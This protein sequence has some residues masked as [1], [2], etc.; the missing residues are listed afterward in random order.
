MHGRTGHGGWLGCVLAA[1]V[2]LASSGVATAQVVIPAPG[3]AIQDPE[4]VYVDAD[5]VLTTREMGKE[6][7]QRLQAARAFA[8]RAAQGAAAD[9]QLVYISLPRL[10]AEARRRVEAG[11]ALTDE[12]RYLHGMTRL[13]YVFVFP[14]EQD[15]VIA[16]PAEPIDATSKLRPMGKVTG[17]AALQLD[18]V[19]TALRTVGPGR[20]AKP[21]G[22]T[23]QLKAEQ[24]KAMVDAL[25][26]RQ[27]IV[28]SQPGQ[29]R[30]VADAMAEAAGPQSVALYQLAE[31]TRLGY[32]CIEADYLMK[33]LALGLDRSP[34]P[35]VRSYLSQ[36]RSPEVNANR[37]WFE[38]SYDRLGVSADG[39]AYELRGPSIRLSTRRSFTQPAPQNIAPEAAQFTEAFNEHIEAL[40]AAI[41]AFADL[42]NLTD[43]AVLAALI[44]ADRLHEKAKWDLEWL[45]QGDGYAAAKW[46]TPTK[47][48][49]LVNY[50]INGRMAI[51][52]GGG[53][54]VDVGPF[55]AAESRQRDASGAIHGK[56]RTVGEGWSR[57]GE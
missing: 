18:D 43:L 19:V 54:L 20:G 7:A 33:R 51:Y 44:D 11:E 29:R 6:N 56:A 40:G 42:A 3:V 37:F 46:P 39:L 47:A 41:P 5:G 35:Q 21:F 9:E 32:V 26:A 25:N 45:L 16:G 52:A 13:R 23:I 4:G 14:D 57:M 34:V 17:R 24:M 30:A 22:C 12:Q 27:A 1:M 2:A 48:D 31:G 53:V 50:S 28:A 49:P 10:F 8:R 15:L 36:L 55:I 38:A